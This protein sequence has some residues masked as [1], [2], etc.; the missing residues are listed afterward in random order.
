MKKLATLLRHHGLDSAFPQQSEV[1]SRNL[2]L[3]EA[4]AGPSKRRR[5]EEKGKGKEK[6]ATLNS[7][8]VETDVLQDIFKEL[9]GLRAEVGNLCAFSQR[10]TTMAENGWRT[11]GQ[12]STC[13]ADLCWHFMPDN[14][15]GSVRTENE[16]DEGVGAEDKEDGGDRAG[17]EEMQDVE[18]EESGTDMADNA[19][20]H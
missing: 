11:Q 9:K 4:E 18:M 6:M 17:N 14:G 7:R 2:N 3:S 10:T 13:V 19:T 15:E 20:L 1:V 12:I 5:V 8:V 16:E